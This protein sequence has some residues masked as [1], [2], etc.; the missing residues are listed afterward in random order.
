MSFKGTWTRLL[1]LSR[2]HTMMMMIMMNCF[3]G[4]VDQRKALSLISSWD[5]CQ[6]S[7]PSRIFD[8]PQAGFESVQNLSS[9]FVE[10]SCAVVI[11]TTPGCQNG[12]KSRISNYGNIYGTMLNWSFHKSFI[13]FSK[14]LFLR[15]EQT[16]I[17]NYIANEQNEQIW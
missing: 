3:C 4:M 16:K 2:S 12:S 9:G 15:L 1:L 6:R 10:W 13:Y 17:S 11:T 8:M 5:H 14:F 7:S